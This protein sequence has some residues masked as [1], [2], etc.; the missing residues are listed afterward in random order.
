MDVH[1]LIDQLCAAAGMIM[2]DESVVAL[3]RAE[4]VAVRIATMA[5]AA[6]DISAL[7]AA[8]AV[9]ADRQR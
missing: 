4:D 3:S 9:L 1:D 2:E 7:A 6:S 5:K 8:A